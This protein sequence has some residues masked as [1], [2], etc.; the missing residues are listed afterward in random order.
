VLLVLS[1]GLW[2]VLVCYS[3]PSIGPPRPTDLERPTESER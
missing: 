2:L 3:C 1:A